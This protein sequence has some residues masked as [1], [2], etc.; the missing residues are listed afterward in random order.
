MVN[1]KFE[2]PFQKEFKKIDT[3]LKNKIIKQILK[4][5]EQPDLGKP[6]KHS[7]KGTRKLYIKP[8]HLAYI[9]KQDTLF[10]TD[11]YHKDNQ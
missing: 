8:Y 7:R 10:I 2:K 5:K 4:L 1:I 3:Q 6:M 9:M 11:F